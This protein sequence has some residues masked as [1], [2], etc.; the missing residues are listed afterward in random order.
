MNIISEVQY[1]QNFNEQEATTCLKCDSIIHKFDADKP[2][3]TCE[4]QS[5]QLEA[6]RFEKYDALIAKAYDK[7]HVIK[8]S[9]CLIYE[10]AG[11]DNYRNEDIVRCQRLIDYLEN[12]LAN[13]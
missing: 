5:E 7:L 11:G 10:L 12:R 8:N 9:K 1:S 2:C 13:K 3:S 4:K 6:E